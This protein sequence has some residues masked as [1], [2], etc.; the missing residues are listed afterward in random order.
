M[1]LRKRLKARYILFDRNS[2]ARGRN[3]NL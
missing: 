3:L 1:C 2:L